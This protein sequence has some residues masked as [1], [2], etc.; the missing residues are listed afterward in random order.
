LGSGDLAPRASDRQA[1]VH[2]AHEPCDNPLLDDTLEASE[3]ALEASSGDWLFPANCAQTELL[4]ARLN[5]AIRAS[6]VPH[7][8][9]LTGYSFRHTFVEA[10]RQAEVRPEI[11]R[12]LVGHQRPTM[13][14]QHGAIRYSYAQLRASMLVAQNFY[15]RESIENY[16]GSGFP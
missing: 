4:S 11:L 10:M 14:D 8:P 3:L 1:I 6:G 12:L 7:S 9:A 15:G 5:K 13:T 16:G 2:A